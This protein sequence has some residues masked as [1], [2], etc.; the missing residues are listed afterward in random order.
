M[1]VLA[2]VPQA[3]VDGFQERALGWLAGLNELQLD[4]DLSPDQDEKSKQ[5]I[6]QGELLAIPPDLAETL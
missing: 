1:L 2:A 5:K 6:E 4:L 3:A